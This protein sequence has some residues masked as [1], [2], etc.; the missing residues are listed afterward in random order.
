M[1]HDQIPSPAE[2]AAFCRSTGRG[3]PKTSNDFESALHAWSDWT[4]KIAAARAELEKPDAPPVK[5][6]EVLKRLQCSKKALRS[7][8]NEATFAAVVQGDQGWIIRRSDGFPEIEVKWMEEEKL[9]RAQEK[10]RKGALAKN[11]KS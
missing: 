6:E 1:K 7:Y 9:K 3:I 4:H 11:K 8:W 10:A 5:L 2:F